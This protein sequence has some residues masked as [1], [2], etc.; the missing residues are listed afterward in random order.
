MAG[1][2]GILF[3]DSGQRFERTPTERYQTMAGATVQDTLVSN[4]VAALY[5]AGEL[6]LARTDKLVV[7]AE[8]ARAHIKQRGF[9]G[10]LQVP[11]AGISKSALDI[12]IA[13]KEDER[14]REEIF[15]NSPTGVGATTLKLAMGLGASLIDPINIASGFVPVVGEARYAKLLGKAPGA[16]RRTAVRAGV[17]SVEGLAGAALV[18]PIIAGSKAYEQADYGMADSLL[19]I[20]FGGVFGAGLHVI[21]G[22]LGDAWKHSRGS[23]GQIANRVAPETRE[24]GL[25]AAIAQ[26]ASGERVNIE[27]LMRM[28]P[29]AEVHTLRERASDSVASVEQADA[30]GYHVGEQELTDEQRAHFEGLRSQLPGDQELGGPGAREAGQSG[31]PDD[32]RAGGEPLKVY[33]GAARELSAADFD[34]TALGFATEHPSSGLGVFFTNTEENAAQYGPVSEHHLDIRNP[35]HVNVEDLQGFDSL[36]E[37]TAFREKLRA[38]G[39]D[40]MVIDASHLGGP[41]NYVAFAPEQVLRARPE[42]AH[43]IDTSAMDPVRAAAEEPKLSTVA[44]EGASDY[45]EEIILQS[46]D[47]LRRED[48]PTDEDITQLDEETADILAGLKEEGVE[49]D[50]AAADELVADA[51][52]YANAARAAVVCGLKHA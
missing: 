4:P 32:G 10:R 29:A 42:A 39:H 13:R 44:D 15:Q 27:P 28:D 3:E 26:M 47:V 33:R 17:G 35:K 22:A 6:S 12:L 11:D 41:V 23:A 20:G 2:E 50:M 1:L 18:E 45:G 16:L 21:G 30:D 40:G 37:A 48:V 34:E 19:N 52:S 36:A 49:L 5:R 43:A 14:L 51:E 31:N 38:E 8:E 9:E 7:P 24:A 25:R 46:D